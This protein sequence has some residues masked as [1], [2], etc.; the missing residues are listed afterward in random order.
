[1]KLPVSDGPGE[2]LGL[3]PPAQD[4]YRLLVQGEA[5]SADDIAVSLGLSPGAAASIVDQLRDQGL[6]SGA[7]DGE[8]H[9]SPPDVSLQALLLSEQQKVNNAIQELEQ[10]RLWVSTLALEYRAARVADQHAELLEVAVGADEAHR[11]DWLIQ[12]LARHEI[13]ILDKPPYPVTGGI[14]PLERE[15]LAAGVRYRAI[16]E[17]GSMAAERLADIRES[18]SAGEEARIIPSL[19]LKLEI[20]D[21]RIALIP[22]RIEA[23]RPGAMRTVMLYESPIVEA[24]VALFEL[25][26]DRATPISAR[27][28]AASSAGRRSRSPQQDVLTLLATGVKDEVIATRLDMSLRTV[29]RHIAAILRDLNVSTRFQAGL[30]ARRRG[31][32]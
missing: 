14:N 19:P 10:T 24:L 31:L 23:G 32:V 7:H 5:A 25:L 26:W 3:S 1:M 21:A 27:A 11:R 16:Y 28:T 29:R 30:E 12:N 17:Q 6:V 20:A 15:R 18:V 9:A 8:I 22:L 13:L 2:L 4:A